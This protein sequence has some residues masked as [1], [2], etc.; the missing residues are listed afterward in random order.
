MTGSKAG[1]SEDKR[2]PKNPKENME[3]SQSQTPA[4]EL[5]K[6]SRDHQVLHNAR[7]STQGQ[8]HQPHP[9][10]TPQ[11]KRKQRAGYLEK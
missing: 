1:R 5:R 11:K 4:T 9:T 6:S 2:H 3:K 8:N 7:H 10:T